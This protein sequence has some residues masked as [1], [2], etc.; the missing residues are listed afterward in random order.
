[1]LGLH[2]FRS[3][4][5]SFIACWDLSIY[6]TFCPSTKGHHMCIS[7]LI[8]WFE[9]TKKG[10]WHLWYSNSVYL[11][12]WKKTLFVQSLC[13]LLQIPDARDQKRNNKETKNQHSSDHY[14]DPWRCVCV[15]VYC[16]PVNMQSSIHSWPNYFEHPWLCSQIEE[17]RVGRCVRERVLV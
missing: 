9:K 1:M 4:H 10:I 13:I 15:C 11:N 8:S 17:R 14:N 3:Q 12:C 5:A 2:M 7:V 16:I 6:M